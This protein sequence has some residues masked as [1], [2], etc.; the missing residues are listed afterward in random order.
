[1]SYIKPL[2]IIHSSELL[3]GR[4]TISD[5]SGKV[6]ETYNISNNDYFFSVAI[7]IDHG[8]FITALYQTDKGKIKKIFYP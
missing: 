6:I 3:S 5:D 2:I 8:N 1:M 7:K 4:L